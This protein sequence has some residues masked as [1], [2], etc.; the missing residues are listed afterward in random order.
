MKILF[1]LIFLYLVHYSSSQ[2]ET[3][4]KKLNETVNKTVNET[5]NETVNETLN[6]TVNETMSTEDPWFETISIP[7]AFMNPL[8]KAFSK[9]WEAKL[10]N[11]VSQYLYSIS[12]QTQAL[13]Y[14]N[15]TQVPCVFQGSYYIE[16]AKSL[17]DIIEFHIIAPNNTIIY[18]TASTVGIF[19][20]NLVDKG[21][22]TIVFN[23][24]FLKGKARATLMINSG[25]NLI[26]KKDNLSATE[27]KLDTI[28]NLLGKLKQEY[29]MLRGF[30]RRSNE[31]LSKT[32]KY[33]FGFS[34]VET[35]ILIVVTIWQYFY[36]K[37]LFEIKGSL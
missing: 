27:K 13:F 35:L 12:I 11:F 33:F 21:L 30:N 25:Q 19:S 31:Q 6:E 2:N 32:N 5:L 16:E 28:I 22:Y 26:L 20:L 1:F 10:T 29:Q 8:F 18:Q 24:T 3:V 23:N 4:N 17:D 15:I 7:L 9:E 34:L 14:E 37:H 36:L